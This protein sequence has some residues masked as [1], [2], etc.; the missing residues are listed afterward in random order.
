MNTAPPTLG[1]IEKAAADLKADPKADPAAVERLASVL[2]VLGPL[3]KIRVA[4]R[5]DLDRFNAW[6]PSTALA[7]FDKAGPHDPKFAAEARRGIEQAVSLDPAEKA[8]AFDTLEHVTS[9]LHCNDPLV[10]YFDALLLEQHFDGHDQK[11]FQSTLNTYLSACNGMH[12]S[13]Y[14]AD[15]KLMTFGRTCA[16]ISKWG[17]IKAGTPFGGMVNQMSQDM[18]ATVWPAMLVEKDLPF[19]T[20]FAA[21]NLTLDARVA[22]GADRKD[23]LGQLLPPLAKTFPNDPGVKVFEGNALV[24]WAWDARGTSYANTVTPDRMAKFRDRLVAA[25]KVLEAAYAANPADPGAPIALMAVGLGQQWPAA[26]MDLWF[27][28]ALAAHP[29]MIPT[30]YEGLGTPFDARVWPMQPKWGGS[31]AQML[32]FG[33]RLLAGRNWRGLIP[34][35]LAVIHAMIANESAQPEAY[36]RQPAVWADLDKLTAEPLRVWP[37]DA[38]YQS[39]RAY[40][41]WKCGQWTIADAMFKQLGDRCVAALF[42]GPEGLAAAKATAAAGG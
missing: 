13:G 17:L 14:P 7:A 38:T 11:A 33:R 18:V 9:V 21:G 24:Q 2:A 36:Y 1:L 31:N 37:D 42:G 27:R 26:R 4:E 30:R 29:D 25:D 3:D 5:A 39:T 40:F 20:A 28:R 16:F 34:Y 35:Q 15:R 19:Q 41:A 6:N 23:V 32:A 22:A 10:N 12:G 8:E